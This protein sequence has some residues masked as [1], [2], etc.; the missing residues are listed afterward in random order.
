MS[1]KSY[2]HLTFC[3][4][5]IQLQLHNLAVII[6]FMS[7]TCFHQKKMKGRIENCKRNQI[8]NMIGFL[9]AFEKRAKTMEACCHLTNEAIISNESSISPSSPSYNRYAESMKRSQRNRIKCSAS[10][11]F[12]N[13][14]SSNPSSIDEA[15]VPHDI[16]DHISRNGV[17]DHAIF[18]SLDIVEVIMNRRKVKECSKVGSENIRK[19]IATKSLTPKL[20]AEHSAVK[21]KSEALTVTSST[22]VINVDPKHINAVEYGKD[23]KEKLSDVARIVKE[24]QT[25]IDMQ[26]QQTSN[27]SRALQTINKDEP[28][29]NTKASM[30]GV[31][32]RNPIY[33]II[34]MKHSLTRSPQSACKVG[35]NIE[36]SYGIHRH[37]TGRVVKTLG[38]IVQVDIGSSKPM[39]LYVSSKMLHAQ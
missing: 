10:K 16:K 8:D 17:N 5:R 31:I 26:T 35:D 18:A 12:E 9:V 38:D 27:S 34:P 1:A 11:G 19:L 23:I 15:S 6:F 3:D 37:Q 32:F 24:S 7:A 30:T 28:L 21:E 22:S 14:G 13:L 33:E 4:S 20:V 25:C 39:Y 29:R 36:I 2:I